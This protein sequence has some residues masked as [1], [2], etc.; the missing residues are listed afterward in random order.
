MHFLGLKKRTCRKKRT[1][2]AQET[3]QDPD[4][5]AAIE[6]SGESTMEKATEKAQD[7]V[8]NLFCDV[9]LNIAVTGETGAGKSFFINA[10]RG[11]E[12]D[13]E[14]AAKTGVT[15]TTT[16]ATSYQH[17]TMPNVTFWDLPGVGSCNFQAKR[18]LQQVNFNRYDFFIIILSERFRENNILLATEIQNQEKK[19]YFVRSKIDNDV[20]AE[21]NRRDFNR[22]K[23]LSD[24]KQDCQQKLKDFENPKVF[25]IS[26]KDLS[27]FDFEELVDTLMSELPE[28]KQNALIQSVPVT[29]VAVLKKKVE[30][31]KKAVWAAALS[32]G[33]VAAVPVLGLSLACDASILVTFFTKCRFSLGLDEKSIDRLSER[34]NKPHLKSLIKCPLVSKMATLKLGVSLLASSEVMESLFKFVPGLGCAL[35]AGISFSST[36]LLLKTGLKE[37]ED[38]ALTVLREAGLD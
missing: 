25:L 38:A 19:F 2:L 5:T 6:G 9:S 24:I 20:R 36:M 12:A 7:T 4:I 14:G 22:E 1:A 17:P 29:S 15:E 3:S 37:L 23:M 26:S 27:A 21:E 34:V 13:D 31:F 16:E 11:L 33:A 18:Y 8:H 30:M 10:I 35:A 28:H 32:S